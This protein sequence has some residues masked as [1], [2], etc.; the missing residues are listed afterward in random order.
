M[1]SRGDYKGPV[2]APA[3][4]FKA[5]N[6]VLEGGKEKLQISIQAEIEL[7]EK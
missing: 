3:P 7:S 6:P 1:K 4:E 5:G 2:A